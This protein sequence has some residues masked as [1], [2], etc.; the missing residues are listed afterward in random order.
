MTKKQRVRIAN[1]EAQLKRAEAIVLLEHMVD[2]IQNSWGE[3][4][5]WYSHIPPT[6]ADGRAMFIVESSLK[7]L[8]KEAR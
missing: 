3:P 8:R 2:H 1:Q 4:D 5:M 7:T 6:R